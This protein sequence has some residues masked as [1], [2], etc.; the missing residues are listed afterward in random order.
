VEI[1][2]GGLDDPQVQALLALHRAES[3]GS[4]PPGYRFALDLSGLRRPDVTF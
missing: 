1:R 3:I 4:T 2:A